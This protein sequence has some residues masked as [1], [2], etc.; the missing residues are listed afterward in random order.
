MLDPGR[1]I[2]ANSDKVRIKHHIYNHI[3]L[4]DFMVGLKAK[5]KKNRRVKKTNPYHPSKV[6]KEKYKPLPK[7]KITIKRFYQRMNSF[8]DNKSIVL[9]ESGDSI[10]NVASL[11]MPKGAL[12][13]DQAFYLSIGYTVPGTLG[14]GIAAPD[15]RVITFVGDGAF[16]T[17]AQEVSTII[18]E[19][20]NPIIFVMNNDGYTIER[21]MVDGAFNDI[22]MWK[23]SQL[24]AVFGGGWGCAVKTED[25]LEAALLKAKQRKNDFALIEIQLDRFDCSEAARMYGARYAALKAKKYT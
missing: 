8:I 1:M 23:Y 21:V 16:Q 4:K 25:D 24:P 5:L 14:I 9:G 19:K 13:I 2:I 22:Q 6:L 17:T 3:S 7:Q 11:F 10:F 20:L 12:C 18:R 15:S